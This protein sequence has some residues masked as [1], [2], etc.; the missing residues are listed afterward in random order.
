MH[1]FIQALFQ[2]CFPYFVTPGLWHSRMPYYADLIRRK[3]NEAVL[4][5]WSFID[6]TLR[7]TCCPVRF[8]RQAYSG[9][10]CHHGIKFQSLVVP[11]GLIACLFGLIASH[12][13]DSYMLTEICILLKVRELM[14]VDGSNSPIYQIYGDPAYPQ[15]AHLF[16]GFRNPPAGSI[17]AEWNTQ[18]SKV[19]EVVE[20]AF[21][22]I[23]QKFSFLDLKVNMKIFKSP[24][25]MYYFVGA[26][27]IN[28]HI[29]IYKNKT[30]NYFECRLIDTL[31]TG[32]YIGLL[33]VNEIV[34]INL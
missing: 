8:Q 30:T 19:R 26:F 22:E 31:N 20:W 15:C 34:T 18:L 6:G 23:P 28:L 32:Q 3:S 14:R 24:I 27:F 7:K 17:Q 21:G 9:H 12:R 11:E 4:T 13:H 25:A 33:T 10:K 16:G 5:T 2:V 29:T 1:T